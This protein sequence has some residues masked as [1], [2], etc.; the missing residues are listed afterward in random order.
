MC[1]EMKRLKE[2]FKAVKL[3]DITI[4]DLKDLHKLPLT[5]IEDLQKIVYDLQEDEEK[6]SKFVKR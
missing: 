3:D 4:D 1:R 6:L 5:V 2:E